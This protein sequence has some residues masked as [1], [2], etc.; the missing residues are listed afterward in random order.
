MKRNLSGMF[1]KLGVLVLAA[2]PAIGCG[3]PVDVESEASQ[4]A[5]EDVGV[6]E[7]AITYGG[8]DYLFVTTPKTWEQAQTYCQLAGGYSLV[9][10]NDAAEESF[11]QTQESYRRTQA[12]DPVYNW[13]I[14]LN[15]KGIEGA[16]VWSNGSS[17]YSNW[18]PDEPNNW[19][20]ED[21]VADRFRSFEGYSFEDWN[22]WACGN[23]FPFI[24]ERDPAPTSNRGSFYYEASNT[25]DAQENTHNYSLYLYAGQVF[26]VGTCGVP[27]ASGSGDTY[28]RIKDPSGTEI[29][30]N[31]D[32]G[33][34]CG[35]L[36][37]ISIVVPET[38][39]YVIRAGCYYTGSC[40]G[41]VAF[42]Y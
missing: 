14:G 22:D 17:T 2:V 9:T 37:N 6:T 35:L 28:L 4:A 19:N 7:S 41:T 26:T 13:W 3:G 5:M 32:A 25:N 16:W 34:S 38:G 36:S 31:D 29:A 18:H 23:A 15:D 12:G 11:L 21:C 42:T 40:S 30:K 33:S 8:H 24:C 10:I 1:S 27:G 20:D 39:T